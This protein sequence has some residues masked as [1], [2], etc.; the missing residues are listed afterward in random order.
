M[1][2]VSVMQLCVRGGKK[3][4]CILLLLVLAGTACFDVRTHKIPNW[5]LLAGMGLGLIQMMIQS[6][7]GIFS[8]DCLRIT[9]KFIGALFLTAALGFPIFLFR[10]AGAGDVKTA[11]LICGYLGMS[12]GCQVI[13]T[14]AVLGALWALLKLIGSRK[15][16]VRI[17]FFFRYLART[18]ESG[19]ILPYYI[20]QRDGG[21]GVIPLGACFFLGMA[22]WM[23]KSLLE[24]GRWPYE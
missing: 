1:V 24:S 8:W 14:A 22:L 12:E 15:L 9:G 13:G 6:G 7:C 2:I 16:F 19:Q 21:E 17:V 20:P 10:M 5:W 11:A 18:M 3:I 23:V 4:R